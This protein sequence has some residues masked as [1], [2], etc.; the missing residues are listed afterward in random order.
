MDIFMFLVIDTEGK[1]ILSEI[2]IIDAQGV[3]IYEAYDKAHYNN[4]NIRLNLKSLAEIVADMQTILANNL[5]VCH[6]AE[7]DK[8]ILH[9][10]YKKVGQQFK[11]IEFSCTYELA[12]IYFPN[13]NSYSLDYLCRHLQLQVDG[14]RFQANSAHRAQYDALFTYQLYQKILQAQLKQQ[15]SQFSQHSN[16]FGHSR[17]DTPFQQ[18]PDLTDIYH[19]QFTILTA[20]ID[21]IKKDV[22]HQS[23]GIVI[24]GDAGTGKTHLMMR[25]AKARLAHN[26]LLFIRQPNHHGAVLFHIYS[27]IL[28]SLVEKVPST[29]Y[30]QLEYLLAKSFSKI[31][32]DASNS[33]KNPSQKAQNIL[34]LL[35]EDPL[36][37]YRLGKD[38]SEIK[39]KNWQHIEKMT[40]RWWEKEF[41]FEG[42]A[43]N[44]IRGLIKFCSYS[45]PNKRDLVR[46][47]L[48]GNELDAAELEKI[49][50]S[51]WDED[52]SLE[53]FSLEAITVFG[54]L[55]LLDEPLL[56]VFD[57]LEG[58]K[59][60]E[61]ILF[62]FGEAVKELFTHVPNSLL[63]FNVFPDRWQHFKSFFD[64][65]VIH[66][67]AQYQLVLD[68]PDNMQLIQILNLK[69]QPL[70]ITIEQ[71]FLPN[72]LDDILQQNSVR[73]VLNRASEYYRFKIDDIPLPRTELNFE[74]EIRAEIKFLKQEITALKQQLS[75]PVTTPNNLTEITAINHFE[76]Y[77]QQYRNILE[78]DYDTKQVIISDTDDLGKLLIITEAF[79]SIISIKI[80]YLRLGKRKLPEH[81]LIETNQQK[82][83]I[84]FLNVGS[85]S[86][87]SRIR[88]FN[89]LVVSHKD[90]NFILFRD[91]RESKPV[92]KVTS[93]EIEKLNN[94]TN[95]NFHYM[96]RSIRIDFELIYKFITDIQNGEIDLEL[97]I[98]LKNAISYF[99]EY[100]NLIK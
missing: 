79:K 17:V 31:Q 58:L 52:M 41:G 93:A 66:R 32:I 90:I 34:K 48:A 23:K 14:K 49:G 47:W 78:Q 97:E 29:N 70:N 2:A 51:D 61:N 43:N 15:L 5:I 69:I 56:I 30:S 11:N 88:N 21:E 42:Y 63:I 3:V 6:Y 62:Q 94:S 75:V 92:G 13:L 100:F 37:I 65:S 96:S 57:Q 82:F 39:Y 74:Q 19:Q 38:K 60:H 72:E 45:E 80:D 10:S 81:L 35:S 9:N 54:K 86:F 50:L 83:V 89:E 20:T 1:D 28:E 77:I 73:A 68:K 33:M 64:D 46:R 22:N 36:N 40:L 7:H 4:S 87:S 71:L 27:R 59:F 16:P 24:I 76:N 44:I 18:H 84:A 85:S 12:K 53:N 67:M 91:A 55:S 25:L 8:E 99:S 95:G 98:A 26:R